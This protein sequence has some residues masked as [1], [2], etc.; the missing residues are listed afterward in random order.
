MKSLHTTVV[1]LIA[2]VISLPLFGQKKT[3]S[4][5]EILSQYKDYAPFAAN[6]LAVVCKKDTEHCGCI[7]TTGKVVIPFLYGM[8]F[9]YF[10]KEKPM[11]NSVNRMVAAKPL[12]IT[13]AVYGII[14]EKGETILPFEYL[15]D[16]HNFHPLD[17]YHIF[18]TYNEPHKYGVVDS[19]GNVVIPFEYDKIEIVEKSNFIL[20]K[21]NRY[22]LANTKGQLILP[23][24]YTNAEYRPLIKSIIIEKETAWGVYTT[25][26]KEILPIQFDG[27]ANSNY[28]YLITIKDSLLSFYSLDGKLLKQGRY[29]T[30]NGKYFAHN[31]PVK[32]PFILK[33]EGKYGMLNDKLDTIIPFEYDI[34][35]KSFNLLHPYYDSLFAVKKGGKYGY[36]N[37]YNQSKLGLI[38]TK[39]NTSGIVIQNGKYGWV[40]NKAELI[41]PCVFDSITAIISN[42]NDFHGGVGGSLFLIV[43]K[44]GKEALFTTTGETISAY[45]SID[46]L[47]SIYTQNNK[48]YI[49]GEKNGK[50]GA[51]NLDGGVIVPFEYDTVKTDFD[52]FMRFGKG[53]YLFTK[54]KKN[55]FIDWDKRELIE[56]HD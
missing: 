56:A 31:T 55:Y 32:F 52:L 1:M 17:P 7:D 35:T 46:S 26:G 40:N 36:I 15:T 20:K 49:I 28:Q 13:N 11:F 42:N 34:L 8:N 43:E 29:E 24:K 37:A 41:L 2:L 38:F 45:N 22:G 19:L 23:I 21:N 25:D 10:I 30:D 4:R 12:T 27:I 5:Q 39:L 48:E 47:H 6:G 44:D 3:K 54:G 51:I 33:K 53:H 18:K 50:L 16:Y 14:N 9:F